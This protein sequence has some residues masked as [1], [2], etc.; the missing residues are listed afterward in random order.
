MEVLFLAGYAVRG[1]QRVMNARLEVI[2]V[3]V[4]SAVKPILPSC[5]NE[6]SV[7][8]ELKASFL[9][10]RLFLSQA[11]AECCASITNERAW[12]LA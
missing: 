8:C 4:Y 2:L 5:M 12:R 7:S 1:T 3:A 11:Y 6:A 9:T 10:S